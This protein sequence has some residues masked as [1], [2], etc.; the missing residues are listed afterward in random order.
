MLK[1]LASLIWTWLFLGGCKQ[2]TLRPQS[3]ATNKLPGKRTSFHGPL[4]S[5]IFDESHQNCVG[6]EHDMSMVMHWT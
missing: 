2:G 6:C 3:Y 1:G 5:L 4:P